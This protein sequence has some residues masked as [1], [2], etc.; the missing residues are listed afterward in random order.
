MKINFINNAITC[1]IK[2]GRYD[3]LIGKDK[4][5]IISREMSYFIKHDKSES[6]IVELIDCDSESEEEITQHINNNIEWC[7]NIKTG[8]SSTLTEIMVFSGLP[9]QSILRAVEI[10]YWNS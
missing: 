3:P 8:E 7:S 9:N 1:L 5:Y 2:N 4:S 6:S 10:I